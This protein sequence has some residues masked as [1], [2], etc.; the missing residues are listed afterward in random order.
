[1]QSQ[2]SIIRILF[3][4]ALTLA[5]SQLPIIEKTAK[6]DKKIFT[7]LVPPLLGVIKNGKNKSEQWNKG[8]FT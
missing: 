8:E 3:S 7:P 5:G 6:S 4:S 2:R 1:M